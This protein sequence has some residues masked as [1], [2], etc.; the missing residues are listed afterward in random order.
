[1]IIETFRR[2]RTVLMSNGCGNIGAGASS[3]VKH[4]KKKMKTFQ[5]PWPSLIRYV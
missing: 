5:A 3:S 2:V 4:F 1:M